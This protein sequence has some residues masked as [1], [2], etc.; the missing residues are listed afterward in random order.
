MEKEQ[1]R[2]LAKR[3]LMSL[4]NDQRLKIAYQF[5]EI[6]VKLPTWQQAKTIAITKAMA[7]EI[8]TDLLI[9]AAWHANK[10]VV[11][12]KTFKSNKMSFYEYQPN[13]NLVKTNFGVLEPEKTA[14]MIPKSAID[15][16]I[17]PG[18]KFEIATNYRIGYG[19]GFYDNYLRNYQGMTIS[20]ATSQ[21]ITSAPCWPIEEFD[22]PVKK[23]LIV[24]MEG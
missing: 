19:G 5:K 21:M 13:D 2:I 18:L 8:P 4:S 20:L 15:L 3:Y 23:I 14:K 1:Q 9:E 17:V 10:Q 16:V 22:Q 7:H 12:P 6:L 24:K 11:I